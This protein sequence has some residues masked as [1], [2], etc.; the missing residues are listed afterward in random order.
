LSEKCVDHLNQ[1][2]LTGG[3][4]GVSRGCEPLHALQHKKILNGN[5]SLLNV[6]LVLILRRYVLFGLVP[7]IFLAIFTAEIVKCAQR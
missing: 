5:V 4:Q 7:G 2:F 6:T 1:W 3:R